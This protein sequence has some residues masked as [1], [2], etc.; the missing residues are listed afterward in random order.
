MS[1]ME[2]RNHR[3]NLRLVNLPANAEG[4]DTIKFIQCQLSVWFPSL[5]SRGLIKIESAHCIYSGQETSSTRRRTLIFMILRYNNRQVI[6][7]A[8]T[9]AG[10][11][12]LHGQSQ[13]LFFTEYSGTTLQRWTASSSCIAS[14]KQKGMQH[15]L[16]PASP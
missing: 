15:F 14:L 13:L 12:I 3:N 6:M 10:T 11:K 7:K 8:Y 9:Q 16:Y 2:N 4:S 1:E 5:Y